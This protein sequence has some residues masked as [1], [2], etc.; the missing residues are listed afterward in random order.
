MN[1][2]PTANILIVDDDAKSLLAMLRIW[3]FG[4]QRRTQT[5]YEHRANG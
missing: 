2:E 3:L 5:I 4:K 1:T